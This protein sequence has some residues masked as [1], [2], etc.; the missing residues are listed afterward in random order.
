[1]ENNETNHSKHFLS[2]LKKGDTN[3]F[4]IIF[5]TYYKRLYAFS[6]QY[7]ED[8]FAAEEIVEETLL[9]LWQ[10][11]HKLEKIENLK[12]YLY[13]MVRNASIDHLKKEKKFVRLDT[14]KHD[15]ISL[16]EQFIIE[17]ET[18]AIL[19]QALETL[20]TKCRK[21]FELSCLDGIKYKDI[22][23]DLQISINT[24][25]SQRARAI[26]LLKLYLKNHH[27]IQILLASL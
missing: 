23:E 5:D 4:K 26:G 9:K 7:T 11:R 27:F 21:V 17:E 25:K 8:S 19:F 20:P 2:L 13:S 15:A 16:K 18:H 12:S 24:V 3:T 14:K 6:L 22:A 1:M 10:K